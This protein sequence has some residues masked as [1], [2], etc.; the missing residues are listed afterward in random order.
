MVHTS[1]LT[2][3]QGE[4]MLDLI[5]VIFML[6]MGASIVIVVGALAI[7]IGETTYKRKKRKGKVW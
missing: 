6:F 1:Q 4:A 2:Q 5:G 7:W 3:T